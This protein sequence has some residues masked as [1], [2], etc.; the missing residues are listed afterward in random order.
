MDDIAL[1]N[2]IV[3]QT[4]KAIQIDAGDRLVWVPKSII[5]IADD[6]VK[7]QMW[8]C[9]KNGIGRYGYRSCVIS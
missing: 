1:T 7:C 5:Q 3:K 6:V 9:K 8:F 2:A 4:E